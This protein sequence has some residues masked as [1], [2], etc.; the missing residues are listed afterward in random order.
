M[1]K[2]D[3]EQTQ[4]QNEIFIAYALLVTM[5]QYTRVLL[6][7]LMPV[8]EEKGHQKKKVLTKGIQ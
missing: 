5:K 7:Q 2:I 8:E 3:V 1:G 6:S 4:E